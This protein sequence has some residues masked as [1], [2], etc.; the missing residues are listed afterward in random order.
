MARNEDG[1]L[2]GSKQSKQKLTNVDSGRPPYR[3][4]EDDSTDIERVGVK[5]DLAGYGNGGRRRELMSGL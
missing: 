4:R 5:L 1:Q 3:N 2:Q